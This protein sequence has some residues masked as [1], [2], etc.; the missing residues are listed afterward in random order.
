M[1]GAA[2]PEEGEIFV[3]GEKI[4]AMDPGLSRQLGIEVIYQELILAPHVSVAETSIWARASERAL[5][6]IGTQ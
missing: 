6:L 2:T 1:A 5:L 4:T 3:N